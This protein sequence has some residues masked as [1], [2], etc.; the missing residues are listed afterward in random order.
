MIRTIA[1]VS[2]FLKDGYSLHGSVPF[3]ALKLRLQI[4]TFNSRRRIKVL[5]VIYEIIIDMTNKKDFHF[6]CF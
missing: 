5:I 3:S 2:S 1:I 4:I 6:I